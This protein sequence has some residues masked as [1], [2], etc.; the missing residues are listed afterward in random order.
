MDSVGVLERLADEFA[1]VIPEV[2]SSVKHERWKPGIG[3]FE[4]ERQLEMILEALE[5]SFRETLETG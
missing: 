1:S 5:G 3:L 2:D 4:E